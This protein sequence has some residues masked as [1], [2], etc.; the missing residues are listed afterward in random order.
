MFWTVI[1]N[2]RHSNGAF[3]MLYNHYTHEQ[4]AIA[5]Y[6][7]ICMSAA[8][9]GLPYHAVHVL[10]SDGIMVRQEIFIHGEV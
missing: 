7:E 2:Q 6:H 8:Q 5:R 10:N 3:A 9:S 1:E 4:D